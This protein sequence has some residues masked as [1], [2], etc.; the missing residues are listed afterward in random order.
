MNDEAK[1][2]KAAYQREWYRKHPGKAREYQD[3]YWK[4]K[5]AEAAADEQA[6]NEEAQEAQ[7]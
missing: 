4:K 3:R 5:A 6:D 2:A 1:K 7:Q